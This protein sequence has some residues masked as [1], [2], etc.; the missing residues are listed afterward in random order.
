MEFTERGSGETLEEFEQIAIEED[1]N[2]LSEP[3]FNFNFILASIT[4]ISSILILTSL[5]NIWRRRKYHQGAYLDDIP[6][7]GVKSAI[8]NVKSILE[9]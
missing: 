7:S 9:L 5:I 4:V 8:N 3:L 2:V 1:V 6:I